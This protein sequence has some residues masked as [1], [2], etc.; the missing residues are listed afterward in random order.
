MGT[1]EDRAPMKPLIR[2]IAGEAAFYAAGA[3]LFVESAQAAIAAKGRFSVALSGGSTPK[4]IYALLA[5]EDP[6]RNSVDWSKVAFF[7]GDERHV[8]P[9]HPDSNYRMANEALLSRLPIDAGRQVFRIKSEMTDAA[10]AAAEYETVLKQE[11]LASSGWPELDLM[12]LGM[13]PEGHTLS[14]FPG[15][16]ALEEKSRWVISNWVGKFYTD[17]ITMTAPVANHAAK[18]VFLVRGADKQ[19]AL[20]AVLEGPYEP[21]QLP[22]QLIEPVKQPLMWL[23]G[24]EAAGL[25]SPAVTG[26]L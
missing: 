7:W 26:S 1:E 9:D 13:G 8:P 16:K 23:I 21:S 25:L 12:L 6:W 4:G 5:S 2:T 22:A 14:L 11:L 19:L 3:D 15:T 18:V 17:R 20:K 10:A 24:E